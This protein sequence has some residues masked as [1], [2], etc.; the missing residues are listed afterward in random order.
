MVDPQWCESCG[1]AFSGNE[2]VKA[3]GTSFPYG[4]P[5]CS[6][7]EEDRVLI[8]GKPWRWSTAR[9]YHPDLPADPTPGQ[10]YSG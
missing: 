6:T 4:C 2:L 3:G 8:K 7:R 1:L 5:E 9:K 10:H